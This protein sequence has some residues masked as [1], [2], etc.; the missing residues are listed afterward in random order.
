MTRHECRVVFRYEEAEQ[1]IFSASNEAVEKLSKKLR[2]ALAMAEQ[3]VI[4]PLT[5]GAECF[6]GAYQSEGS[7]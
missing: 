6:S 4:T 7:I 2:Q 1:S 5:S 3:D